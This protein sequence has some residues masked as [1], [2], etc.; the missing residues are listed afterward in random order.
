MKITVLVPVR[1]RAVGP[2]AVTFDSEPRECDVIAVSRIQHAPMGWSYTVH[3]VHPDI[4]PE[5]P[6]VGVN[7]SHTVWVRRASHPGWKPPIFPHDKAGTVMVAPAHAPG[8][9]A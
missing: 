1:K 9:V 6:R 8:G 4:H 2:C 5:Y 7:G 3:V